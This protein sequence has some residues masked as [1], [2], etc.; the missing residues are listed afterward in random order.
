MSHQVSELEK[1]RAEVSP[2]ACWSL[3][4]LWIFSK[5]PQTV[6]PAATRKRN[7]TSRPPTQRRGA[8]YAGR[9][10]AG[11]VTRAVFQSLPDQ[12]GIPAHLATCVPHPHPAG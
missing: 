5:V 3:V 1:C 4:K 8:G 9:P 6:R 2:L 7:M 11:V 10:A 12:V